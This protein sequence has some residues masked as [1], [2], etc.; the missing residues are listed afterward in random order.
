[1]AELTLTEAENGGRFTVR[2]GDT[3]N[4]HL[5]E[6]SAA[7]YRWTASSLDELRVT[8]KSHGYQAT[9]AA[10]G[11]AGTT[12]WR[13][14]ASQPGTARVELKKSRPWE[15]ADSASERFAVDLD[16]VE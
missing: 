15:P 3:I 12:V 14:S 8:V 6:N 11:S 4:I 13:V 10:V 7:G 16:I 9:G 5:S 1:M 2:V